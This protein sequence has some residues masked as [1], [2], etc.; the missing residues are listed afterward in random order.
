LRC[1]VCGRKI[2]GEPKKVI[3]EGAKMLVCEECAKLGSVYLEPEARVPKA[4]YMPEK[5]AKTFPTISMT[6]REATNLHEETEL[7]ENFGSLIREV[8][9]KLGLTHEDLG[10]KIGEKVSVLKKVESEKMFPDEKLATKLEHVLKVKLLVQAEKHDLPETVSS[11]QSPRLTLG[12]IAHLKT[13]KR[14]NSEDEGDHS[15]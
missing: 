1:E 10:R 3:I 9:E 14:R 5:R 8:R 2:R 4:S 6:K 13:G 7:I 12:E 15:S 11:P